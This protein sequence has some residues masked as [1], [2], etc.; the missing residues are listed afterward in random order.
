MLVIAVDLIYLRLCRQRGLVIE[1]VENAGG[2]GA[3]PENLRI[4]YGQQTIADHDDTGSPVM[5]NGDLH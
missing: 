5:G 4:D 1:T 2:E 3:V